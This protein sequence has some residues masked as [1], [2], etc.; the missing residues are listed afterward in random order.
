[1]SRGLTVRVSQLSLTPGTQHGAD[2]GQLE[3]KLEVLYPG[4]NLKGV[5]M[6]WVIKATGHNLQEGGALAHEHVVDQ[7]GTVTAHLECK[8]DKSQAQTARLC[9]SWYISW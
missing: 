7:A 4:R 6:E 5:I 2:Y 3:A 9:A 1:L 8:Q